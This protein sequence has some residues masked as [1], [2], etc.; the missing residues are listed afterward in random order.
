[1]KRGRPTKWKPIFERMMIGGWFNIP[2]SVDRSTVNK[3]AKR[4]GFKLK[5]KKEGETYRIERIQ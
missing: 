3:C 4:F 1:M 2:I 5:T